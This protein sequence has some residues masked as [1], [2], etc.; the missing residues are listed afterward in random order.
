MDEW[1]GGCMWKN[2]Q[3]VNVRFSF[4]YLSTFFALVSWDFYC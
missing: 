3:K 4:I 1:I 2:E